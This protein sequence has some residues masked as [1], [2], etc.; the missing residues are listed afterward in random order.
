MSCAIHGNCVREGAPVT[1]R[2]VTASSTKQFL[3]ELVDAKRDLRRPCVAANRWRT[4]RPTRL[5]L[6]WFPS[7]RRNFLDTARARA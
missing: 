3:D 1:A 2:R 5:P 4:G 6:T 7:L